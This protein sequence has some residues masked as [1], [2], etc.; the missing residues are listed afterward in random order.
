MKLKNVLA[1]CLTLCV[2]LIIP[3]YYVKADFNGDLNGDGKIDKGDLNDLYNHFNSKDSKYD[4]NNDGTV[5]IYDM[6]YYSK[7]MDSYFLQTEYT[8]AIG[9]TIDYILY[10]RPQPKAD[11]KSDILLPIGSK[12]YLHNR[13]GDFYQV[14]YID[15]DKGVLNGFIT[16]HVDVIRDDS[17]NSFLGVLSEKYESNGD[18]GCISSGQGD[19]GGKS[20]GA[21]QLSSGV[22]ALDSFLIWLKDVNTS[23]YSSLDQARKA[24][25]GSFGA[26]FDTAWKNLANSNY[27]DFLKVQQYYIK[28]KYYDALS[29]NLLNDKT[30]S[31]QLNNFATKNVLWSLAVQHGVSGAQRLIKNSAA[32]TD[33]TGFI[34]S[35]YAERSKINVYFYN[36]QSIA[37][38]LLTRFSSEKNDALRMLSLQNQL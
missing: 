36:S 26:N 11:S 6:N 28:S 14:S 29:N 12:V 20:Y 23:Y 35:V 2:L 37:N 5:D 7:N 34:N 22:G 9:I 15:K 8:G 18:P 19:Y 32:P 16:R 33:N 10:L 27:D 13:T 24:D 38:A 1:L 4:L 31:A 17:D 25:N 3:N 21:W 30:Y